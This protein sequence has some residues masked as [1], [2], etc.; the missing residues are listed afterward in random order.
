MFKPFILLLNSG[1]SNIFEIS[2]F[3]TGSP[4]KIFFFNS[5][6]TAVIQLCENIISYHIYKHF[7]IGTKHLNAIVLVLADSSLLKHPV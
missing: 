3:F 1:V 6:E 7:V 2:N 4:K 5:H